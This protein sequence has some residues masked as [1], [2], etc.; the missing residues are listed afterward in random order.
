MKKKLSLLT[1][2]VLCAASIAAGVAAGGVIQ[3]IKA[4]LRQDFI[5]EVDGVVREFENVDG[6][7]VYPIL[8]DGTTYLPVRAI[9]EI[10]GKTVYWYETEKRIA[11]Q[12]STTTVTDA[13][14]I[15]DGSKGDTQA[16]AMR[17]KTERFKPVTDTADF[18]SEERAKAIALEKAGL[19]AEGVI[20]QKVKLERDNGE[21]YYEVEFK[22]DRIEYD[23][24]IAAIDGQIRAWEIDRD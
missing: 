18:I 10:M 6:E 23:A 1:A 13:D 8:Y 17:T 22:K 20:F 4:E 16:A 12:D 3:E 2:G 14:V 19:G 11:L 5:V 21:W 9:G 24:D 7:R 15:L